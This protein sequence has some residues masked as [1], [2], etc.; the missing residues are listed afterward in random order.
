M[1]LSKGFGAMS[2]DREE[3]PSPPK[4]KPLPSHPKKIPRNLR[5]ACAKPTHT[6]ATKWLPSFVI[7]PCHF[8]YRRIEKNKQGDPSARKAVQ[9]TPKKR[10]LLRRHLKLELRNQSLSVKMN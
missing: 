8:F 7:H 2:R 6:E 3:H 4:I 1:F 5:I 10:R 9:M